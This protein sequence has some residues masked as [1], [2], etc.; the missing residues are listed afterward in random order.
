MSHPVIP[1]NLKNVVSIYLE[2]MSPASAEKMSYGEVLTGETINYR[3]GAPQFNGLFCQAIFGPVKDWECACGKYKRYRYAGVICDRCG[4][5]VAHS[6]IRRERMGHISLASPCVHPW[7]LRVIP[8]R[9]ALLLDMKSSDIGKVC[10]FSAYVITEINEEMREEYIERITVESENR[11]KMTR[12]EYDAK[13]QELSRQYQISKSSGKFTFDELKD[14]YESDKEIMKT[15]ENNM[16]TKIETITEMAKKELIA[17]KVKDVFNENT[18]RE[19]AQKFGPVFKSGIGAEA[20]QT[21]LKNLD[22]EKEYEEIKNKIGATKGQNKKKLAKK[23]K[24]I[25][26]F[27]S[28][29]TRPEW[30][31]MEKIMVLPPDLRPMLQLDGGRFAASDLNELYR[32]LINRNNRLRKLIQIGAPEVILRNEKRMLQEA[33]EALIDNSTKNGKQVMASTGVKK[34]LKSLTDILK[35]KQGRFRQNLLG[36]RVDYSGRSVIIIGPHLKLEECGLPKEMALEL[37]KP[38]LIGRIIAKSEAGLLSETDQCYNV[39]SARRLVESRKP[40]VYDIMEE[41]IKDKYVLL[42]RA[43]TLHRLG[44]L[45]FKPILVEGKTIQIHPLVCRAF[46]ADFDGDQMAVHLP[47]TT[48]GQEEA[49]D[50]IMA[51]KNLINPADGKLIMAGTQDIHLGAYYL[52]YINPELE[53]QLENKTL[54]NNLDTK[55]SKKTKVESSTVQSSII[56]QKNKIQTFASVGAALLA[57]ENAEITL[58][59][60]IKVRISTFK[61]TPISEKI[62]EKNENSLVL[63]NSEKENSENSE[64]ILNPQIIVKINPQNN[65]AENPVQIVETSIGRLI[66]NQC[67]PDSFAFINQTFVK[68]TYNQLLDK[69]FF[70]LGQ[71]KLVEVLDKLKEI[72][73]KYVTLSGI[74]LSCRDLVTP[75]GKKEIIEKGEQKVKKIQEA[76]EFGLLT[77]K[78]RYN[79]VVAVWRS[80]SSEIYKIAVAAVDSQ[81]NVAF[82]INSGASGNYG[83]VNFI[84]GMRGLS[85]DAMGRTLELPAKR[86]YLEGL[87]GLEYFV[88][89]K[90]HRKGMADTALKTADAGY[91]TRRLVDVAQNLII[92]IEDCGTTDG[93][94]LTTENSQKFNKNLWDRAYGRYLLKDLV[95]NGE[96]IV[97]AGDFLDYKTIQKLKNTNI[98]QVWIRSSTK[99][100]LPRG[101]CQHC[102]GVDFSTH[103]PAAIGVSVGIIGAQ[104]LGEPSTQLVISSVKSGVAIGATSDI[105]GGLPRVEEIFEARIPKYTAPLATF[106]GVI[107]SVEGDIEN[108]FKIVIKSENKEQKIA[109]D[110]TQMKLLVENNSK[111]ESGTPLIAKLDG[112]ILN[113]SLGGVVEQKNNQIIVQNTENSLEEFETTPGF[114]SSVKPGQNIKMGEPLT[115]GA[116]ALQELL[117][118]VGADAVQEYIVKEICDIYFSNG[119]EVDEKHIEVITKQM[120]SRVQ[121]LESGDSEYLS[122]DVLPL[123][124]VINANQKLVESGKE[125][126]IFKRIVTGISRAS[127]STDS[128]L[129]AASFQETARVLVEAAVSRRKDRLWG[130]KENV[131]L[132]QLIPCGTGFDPEKVQNAFE[133]EEEYDEAELVMEEI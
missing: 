116:V 113:I 100:Q 62:S 95:E 35:G 25:K 77:D 44:F 105:T 43:P 21:L 31:V 72:T 2:I 68:K 78:E 87:S 125:I 94:L 56:N 63:E 67:L 22:L 6:S 37:F 132:G 46:N 86:G 90:G 9:I 111:I 79:Q 42:N 54:E 83:Q 81:S 106:D 45:A 60:I 89:M 85:V 7:F 23:I 101:L 126:C 133:L 18:H 28:A 17:F 12:S 119:I 110:S 129:S 121:I 80:S 120:S 52:T 26:Y 114:Y 70:S 75:D 50:L 38:F 24:L 115:E 104:S 102:Y 57:L 128:F 69:I 11:I 16:V 65:S 4:V 47:I 130:L 32:R 109:F 108:G 10:Y 53:K 20:I 74:S 41:V 51:T 19:L 107:Q 96:T 73:F 15:H 58:S 5:E 76:F 27:L 61:K 117:D 71:E 93:I 84:T 98:S 131:I 40:I 14:K 122:G 127:L 118:L 55:I 1:T 112:E 103:K 123:Y 39:H 88:T 91:L 64:L 59:E 36:K 49:R 99:C 82:I 8:S 33:V 29:E 34:P 30:M 124:F 66:F 48:R 92:M 13:F 3:T 97:K